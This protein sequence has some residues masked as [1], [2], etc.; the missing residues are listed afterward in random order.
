MAAA[1]FAQ[2]SAQVV[3]A[4]NAVRI[5]EFYR[6]A[7]QVQNSVWPN[8][9]Q[10]PDALLL[11]TPR[12]EFLTHH[13]TPKDFQPA[14]KDFVVRPRQFEPNLQA[15]FPAFG[16]T[17]VMVIGEPEN[18]SSKTSTPWLI[19]L[20]HEHFHQLQYSQ[21]DYYEGTGKLGLSKAGGGAMWM[22]NYPFPYDKAEVTRA[23]ADLRDL[24]WSTATES[25]PVRF[26]T[27]AAAYLQARKKFFAQL[28]DDDRKYL[29]FQ[30]WQ[31]GIARYTEI[32]VAEAAT[33]YRPSAEYAALADFAPFTGYGA[34][35]LQSTLDELKA[36]VLSQRKREAA[37][38]F[39]AV[40]G[41][42]LDHL[43]PNWKA[44]YFVRPFALGP[45]FDE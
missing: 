19:T 4:D 41:L 20:L 5:R 39:G 12:H 14:G 33:A 44:A 9:N 28:S 3:T 42:L 8:W 11:V 36:S 29:E 26:K 27:S 34:K 23:F 25:D 10:A 15:T 24:L 18:T 35:R 17:P 45:Y 13:A 43:R 22:L 30:L 16:S 37:Y 7:A 6:L 40:E 32:K 31:E 38:S 21:P 2:T 1:A